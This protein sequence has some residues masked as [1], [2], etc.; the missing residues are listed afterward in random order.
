MSE[1][2]DKRRYWIGFDL[3]GTKMLAVVFD[4]R[5][6]PI[7]RKRRKTRSSE[8]EPVSLERLSETIVM[9]LEEIGAGPDAIAGIGCGVPGPLDLQKGLILEAPNLGWKNVALQDYLAKKFRCP[10]VI[11]NDVD[12]GVFGEY[13]VGAGQGFRSVL[14]VFPG[15]GIGG[16][17]VY[18]GRI[19]RGTRSSCMEVGY[20]QMATE[21]SAAGVGPVGTLEGLAS[22]LAISAEAAKAVYRGQAPGLQEIAGTDISRIRSSALAKSIEKGDKAIEQIV[23]RAAQQVGR[24][25]G[26]LINILA[27]DVVI[28][29]GGLVEAM[30]KLYLESVA[31]GIR[32]NVLPSLADCGKLKV[33]ELG[34]LAGATGAAALVRQEAAEQPRK[35][36]KEA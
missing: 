4:E 26:S 3:G 24:G 29:G 1:G 22:R 25:I 6:K 8:G 34:D 11:C 33:S 13:T 20:L 32:R 18:E 36:L 30:P 16:G 5:L 23:K 2:Q 15:T 19:F 12:A 28:L 14:G 27:P 9:S 21:G 10:A 35:K 7:A 17:F 31:E